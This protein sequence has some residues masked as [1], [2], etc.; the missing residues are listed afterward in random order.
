M[1]E[2]AV[3]FVSSHVAIIV[4]C[5]IVLAAL[6]LLALRRRHILVLPIVVWLLTKLSMH[7]SYLLMVWKV[8]GQDT[9]VVCT[10]MNAAAEMV[11]GI[12]MAV[13]IL[14]WARQP[15]IEQMRRTTDAMAKTISE[16]TEEP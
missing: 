6:G 12:Y 16:F 5:L 11:S 8:I 15:T 7:V 3:I 10:A 13:L 2:K 9:V 4:V 14:E 1:N